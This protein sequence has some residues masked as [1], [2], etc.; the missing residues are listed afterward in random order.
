MRPPIGPAIA[1][2]ALAWLLTSSS[3]VAQ[4]I[5]APNTPVVVTLAP[6][7]GPSVAPELNPAFYAAEMLPASPSHPWAI[8][9]RFGTMW[10]GGPNLRWGSRTSPY[11]E[12]SRFAFYATGP[13]VG[14]PRPYVRAESHTVH[15]WLDY[16]P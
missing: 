5:D 16:Y 8:M 11:G 10:V 12:Y 3:A 13:Y 7:V 4:A 15:R 2:A 6:T 14:L 1:A 9:P